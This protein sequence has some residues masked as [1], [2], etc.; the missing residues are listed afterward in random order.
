MTKNSPLEDNFLKQIYKERLPSE[1]FDFFNYAYGVLQTKCAPSDFLGYHALYKIF[2]Q[3]FCFPKGISKRV[4]G[5]ME[6]RGLV[7]KRKRGV[8]L[9]R[10]R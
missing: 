8:E 1:E 7:K 9:C 3:T 4:V 10:K 5:Q 6:N 2:G